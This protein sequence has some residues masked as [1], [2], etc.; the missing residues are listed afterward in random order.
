MSDEFVGDP[1]SG[2]SNEGLKECLVERG[3]YVIGL[4]GGSVRR[5]AEVC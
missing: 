1:L 3:G 2:P 5:S 4:V